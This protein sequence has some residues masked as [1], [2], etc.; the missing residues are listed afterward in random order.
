MERYQIS[1]L[2][3]TAILILLY[4]F[5]AATVKADT[6]S[7]TPEL[8]SETLSDEDSTQNLPSASSEKSMELSDEISEDI[9]EKLPD[10]IAEDIPENLQNEVS[11]DIT[12]KLQDETTEDIS[13]ELPDEDFVP[14]P[15]EKPAFGATLELCS[16]GYVVKGHFTEFLPDTIFARPQYSLDGETWQDCV[17]EW[18]LHGLG[19][20]DS[21]SLH[22]LQNQII[23]YNKFEPL[24]SYL[25]GELDTFYLRLFITMKNGLTYETQTALIE[26]GDFGPVPEEITY[27]A[28]FIPAMLTRGVNA[29]GTRTYCG[30]YQLTVNESCSPE[31][32]AAFL[33]DT[34]PIQIDLHKE[35]KIFT[36]CTIDCPV[37]WKPLSLP[38]LSAGESVSIQDAAEE[39]IIPAG[40]ILQTPTGNFT[41]DEPLGLEQGHGLTDEILLVLNV[42]PAGTNP[43]GVLS[44]SIHGLEIALDCKP[45]GATAI[46]AFALSDGASE[47]TALPDLPLPEMMDTQPSTI[48]SGYTFILACDQEPYRSYLNAEASG[49]NPSPFL[50]GLQI[51][52]GIYHGCQLILAY[53]DTYDFPPDLRIGG[54]GGNHGNAGI[55][56]RNDSTKEGQRP[57]LPQSST[58]RSTE[59]PSVSFPNAE[60]NSGNPTGADNTGDVPTA[61]DVPT[62]TSE[63][64][65]NALENRQINASEIPAGTIEPAQ[66]NAL[67]ISTDI[68]GD[69]QTVPL[70]IPTN[71]AENRQTDTL[72]TETSRQEKQSNSVEKMEKSP[73]KIFLPVT[74][75]AIAGIYITITVTKAITG[76]MAGRISKKP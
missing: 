56:S 4:H 36:T 69:V 68:A 75:A 3:L 73:L 48:N 45:T 41:L 49:E 15:N 42:I 8:T 1:T 7:G 71:E 22:N 20:E 67:G 16:D 65:T 38:R 5:P 50:I 28:N 21:L 26:R 30:G 55:G 35:R 27:T 31:D 51:E 47:W 66:A 11:E 74:A 25:A 37:T 64:P 60:D 53:P 46:H 6:P 43:T 70:T 59:P 52:G 61:G 54:S 12:V 62:K 58:E 39:I 14:V 32:I 17:L 2:I 76:S 40:T 29:S 9:T 33:P 23:L 13:V 18:D 10:E 63:S 19:H 24:K 34:I 44:G 72:L 57:N